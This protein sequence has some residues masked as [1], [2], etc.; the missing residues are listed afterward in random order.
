MIYQV[1]DLV[2]KRIRQN[3]KCVD[4]IKQKIKYVDEN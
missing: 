2:L 3:W 4:D 1:L